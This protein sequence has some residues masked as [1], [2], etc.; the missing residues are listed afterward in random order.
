LGY[1]NRKISQGLGIQDIAGILA[2]HNNNGGKVAVFEHADG[3]YAPAFLT[4]L[5]RALGG[6]VLMGV[7]TAPLL[8]GAV[9][10]HVVTDRLDD[11]ESMAI[12][13]NLPLMGAES[14]SQ[15]FRKTG[16]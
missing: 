9:L 12:E 6:F 7:I 4:A 5:M 16:S 1:T 14:V 2:N 10:G 15:G 3:G 13:A 8:L 11:P